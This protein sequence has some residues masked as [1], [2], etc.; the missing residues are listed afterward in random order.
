MNLFINTQIGDSY[1]SSS[2]KARV[3]TEYWVSKQI[4]CPS[5]G[6]DITSYENNRPVA[7]FLCATCA[8]D[9]EL[10]SIKGKFGIN[11]L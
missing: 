5:C 10:K 6:S 1:T 2:Q 8:E 4:Y 3:I 11:G 7:D 9:Y